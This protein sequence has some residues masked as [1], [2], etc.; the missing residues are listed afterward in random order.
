MA[1][2][3]IKVGSGSPTDAMLSELLPTRS[4]WAAAE[5][6]KLIGINPVNT[7]KWLRRYVLAGLVVRLGGNGTSARWCHVSRFEEGKVAVI[8]MRAE[9]Q[10]NR[11]KRHS[12]RRTER[13][14][15]QRANKPIPPPR[16]KPHRE[17]VLEAFV[18]PPRGV[19]CSVWA[20]GD[21]A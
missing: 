6:S 1:E 10:R 15:A 19:P 2:S 4:T 20:L 14:A 11:V 3:D 5:L 17:A 21:S 9:V 7:T 8:E 13:R 12:Q 16:N 18:I